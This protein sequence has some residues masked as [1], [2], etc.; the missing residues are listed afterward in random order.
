MAN[1]YRQSIINTTG[2]LFE[3]DEKLGFN[4]KLDGKDN[5]SK[6]YNYTY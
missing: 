2:I 6:Y 4:F 1:M 5:K 3:L